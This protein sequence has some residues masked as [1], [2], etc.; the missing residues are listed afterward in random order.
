MARPL[1]RGW[2]ITWLRKTRVTLEMIK[3]EHTLFALPLALLGA[4][5]AARGL[6]TFRSMFWILVAMVGARSS[7][8]AFNRLVD[9]R[10]D[11]ENPR[12]RQRALPTGQVDVHF[13]RIFVVLSSATFILAAAMLNR[14]TLILSAVAL[15]SILL[16][17][18]T[19]RV[20]SLSH[21][22]LGWCL[23]I[24]PTGAWIAIRGEIGSPLP[25]LLSLAALCWTAGF[26]ILY[27]CQDVEFDR[28]S[29]LFSIPQRLGVP[30]AFWLSRL[31][32]L[33]TFLALS[34][35]AVLAGSGWLARV[36]LGLVGVLLIRQHLIIRPGD[37]RRMDEAFFTTNAMVSVLLLLTMGADILLHQN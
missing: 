8:M 30:A 34:E 28:R 1:P 10:Y 2:K 14:L 25:L 20:T 26:D 29:G 36:G 18:Y 13:V 17:S 9:R 3:I 4:L 12:T 31:L 6:P 23:A 35:L 27:A 5:L 11:A 22:I 21:F 32:H 24:A 19:K 7:A 16:Y 37:L 15:S 33:I